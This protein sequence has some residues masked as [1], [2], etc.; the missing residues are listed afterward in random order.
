MRLITPAGAVYHDETAEADFDD[1]CDYH[2]ETRDDDGVF[3][4]GYYD[5]GGGFVDDG[6][7]G[8]IS[9]AGERG[10]LGRTGHSRTHLSVRT[11]TSQCWAPPSTSH[12]CDWRGWL[13]FGVSF[14]NARGGGGADE[15]S[16]AFPA[17]LCG[18]FWP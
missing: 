18:N 10:C 11:S 3:D 9:R 13:H 14:E 16:A 6:D 2:D 1:R 15:A 7:A 17:L 12:G 8:L 4:G 5:D